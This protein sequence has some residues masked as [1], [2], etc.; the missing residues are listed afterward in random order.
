MT[1]GGGPTTRAL[2]LGA[3]GFIGRWVAREL[4]QRSVSVIGA[5]RDAR[6]GREVLER[7]GVRAN[8]VAVDLAQPGTAADLV[9]RLAPTHVYNL[10]GYGVDRHERDEALAER[11]NHELARELAVACARSEQWGGATLLHAG[12]ALEYGAAEGVLDESTEPA[13]T[14]VYGRTKLA[15]TRALAVTASTRGTRA[16]VARLF[17]VFGHGELD[18]RLFPTLRAAARSGA[19]VDLTAGEQRRDF[20]FVGDVASALV[21]LA[22]ASFS[23]GEIVNVAT[24]HVFAVRVFAETVA[25]VLGMPVEHLRFGALATRAEEMPHT[26]VSTARLE[27]LIAR[28]LPAELRDLA[29]RAVR[30]AEA[31]ELRPG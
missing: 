13:P 12:S 19:T 25:R 22:D 9:T 18:A 16:V 24:G 10:A 1:A 30:D 4:T 6:E 3:S 21:D 23:P 2:V 31:R 15:G 17:T 5:V 7:W 28:A 27:A 20:A 11:L 14:T 26:G 8:V 29:E